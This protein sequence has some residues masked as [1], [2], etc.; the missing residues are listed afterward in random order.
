MIW[1]WQIR[2]FEY[3]VEQVHCACSCQVNC[4]LSIFV[5]PPS[6]PCSSLPTKDKDFFPVSRG[7]T[8]NM[9]SWGIKLF[10]V[11]ITC[12]SS[13]ML[14]RQVASLLISHSRHL[15][16]SISLSLCVPNCLCLF[17]CLSVCLTLCLCLCLCLSVCLS[18]SLSVSLSLSFSLCLCA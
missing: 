1:S 2:H 13:A 17:L 5:S 3:V 6:A 4:W 14:W 7:L 15:S 16:L 9:Y 10:H 11:S 12:R 18:L 8:P